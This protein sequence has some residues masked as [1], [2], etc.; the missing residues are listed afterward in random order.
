MFPMRF[1]SFAQINF[2]FMSPLSSWLSWLLLKL[3]GITI[4]KNSNCVWHFKSQLQ[5]AK[6]LVPLSVCSTSCWIYGFRL[7]YFFY[8]DYFSKEP[9]EISVWTEK[10]IALLDTNY[11]TNKW[12]NIAIIKYR[13]MFQ[14]VSCSKILLLW[15]TKCRNQSERFFQNFFTLLPAVLAT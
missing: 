13:K 3:L 12:I 8:W 9:A 15:N 7:Q 11:Q 4:N 6:V 10:K 2:I 1:C 5:V 14:Q